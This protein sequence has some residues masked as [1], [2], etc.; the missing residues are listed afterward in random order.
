MTNEHDL[1]I[2]KQVLKLK[3]MSLN[4]LRDLWYSL[5]KHDPISDSK[6]YMIPQLAYRIQELAY[7]G[8]DEAT[9]RKI[10]Q[11]AHDISK[12][13]KK[14]YKAL[15]GTKIVKEYKDKLHEIFVVAEGFSYNGRVY[16]SLSAIAQQITGTKWNGLVF[17]G[18]KK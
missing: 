13:K 6:M 9:E 15:L 10:Q 7:G 16:S 12:G 14:T 11:V 2:I 3:T 8:T 5:Y 1:N 18:V 4:D 17:F